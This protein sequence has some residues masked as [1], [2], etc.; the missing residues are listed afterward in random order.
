MSEELKKV[1]KNI[2]NRK[3]YWC[4]VETLW[5]LLKEMEATQLLFIC[6]SQA[7]EKRLQLLLGQAKRLD[8]LVSALCC[9]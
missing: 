5:L 8:M 3:R 1:I 7:A 9:F 2:L 4:N 6:S